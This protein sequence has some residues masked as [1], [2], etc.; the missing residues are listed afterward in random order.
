MLLH[1][2]GWA[3]KCQR[4]AKNL[5]CQVNIYIQVTTNRKVVLIKADE[6]GSHDNPVDNLMLYL[7]KKGGIEECSLCYSRGNPLNMPCTKRKFVTECRLSFKPLD[8]LKLDKN[9]LHDGLTWQYFA[10]I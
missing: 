9:V 7:T 1:V 6:L 2:F 8:S 5:P 4:P 10:I 3:N